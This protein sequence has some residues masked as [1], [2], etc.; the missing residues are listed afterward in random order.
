MAEE[1]ALGQTW[2]DGAT[3]DNDEGA[4]PALRVELVDRFGEQ[5][6]PGPCFTGKQRMKVAQAADARGPLEQLLHRLAVADDTEPSELLAHIFLV[7]R[8]AAARYRKRHHPCVQ[9]V[10]EPP[11]GGIDERPR[12]GEECATAI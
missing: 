4:G 6:F 9:L 11:V 5:L 8:S 12:A 3:I 2:T 7:V 10:A 1:L